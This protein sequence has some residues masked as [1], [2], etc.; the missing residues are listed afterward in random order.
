M[1]RLWAVGCLVGLAV[2]V[3]TTLLFRVRHVISVDEVDRMIR[4]QVP[5]GSDKQTVKA[6]IDN[7]KIDS[8]RIEHGEFY[9]VWKYPVHNLDTEKIRELGDRLAEYTGL[10]IY[11]AQSGFMNYNNI[12]IEF[13][14]DKDGHLIGYTVQLVG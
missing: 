9:N 3:A 5:V 7:L 2:I 8:L 12:V 4:D 13:Y 10:V 14:L 11:D 1:R 6:F